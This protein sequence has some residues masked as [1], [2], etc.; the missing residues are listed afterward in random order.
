MRTKKLQKGGYFEASLK[1]LEK[2]F[3]NGLENFYIH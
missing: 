3:L 1:L 2:I